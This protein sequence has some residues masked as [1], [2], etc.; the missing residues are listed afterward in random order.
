MCYTLYRE[1]EID[2]LSAIISKLG[3][4]EVSSEQ[5]TNIYRFCFDNGILNSVRKWHAR[6]NDAPTP[7]VR[8]ELITPLCVFCRRV[9][10]ASMTTK[11]VVKGSRACV[12]SAKVTGSF[13]FSL[14]VYLSPF[15]PCTRGTANK[16]DQTDSRWV[17]R[18]VWIRALLRPDSNLRSWVDFSLGHRQIYLAAAVVARFASPSSFSSAT[19][20]TVVTYQFAENMKKNPSRYSTLRRITLHVYPH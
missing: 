9:D 18:V 5:S 14:S 6:I 7:L 17:V 12:L 2:K 16:L 10:K 19:T 4:R 15:L 13:S 3:A 1:V 11:R 20:T 8:E